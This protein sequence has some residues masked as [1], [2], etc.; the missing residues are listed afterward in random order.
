LIGRKH[1]VE[2]KRARATAALYQIYWRPL[3]CIL[4]RRGFNRDDAQDL[5][6][7]FLIRFIA[8]DAMSRADARKG[9]FRDYLV[10]ALDNFLRDER[11]REQALK[12]GG[13]IERVELNEAAHSEIEAFPSRHSRPHFDSP[14]DIAWATRFLTTIVDFMELTYM[15]N[16]RG[17]LFRLLKPHLFGSDER[18][19]PYWKLALRLRRPP[20]TLR[21][22]VERFRAHFRQIVRDQLRQLYGEARVEEELQNLRE[23]LRNN[24]DV[25]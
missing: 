13:G 2:D 4:R 11:D 19:R 5:T 7:T 24:R 12:R 16:G 15:R 17:L 8:S 23:I 3:F 6:Q 20:A 18:P 25:L 21:K 22:D 14:H 1:S 10:G 9:R